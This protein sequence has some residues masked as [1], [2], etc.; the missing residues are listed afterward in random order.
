MKNLKK[1]NRN[2]LRTIS[3]NGLL[4]NVTGAVGGLGAAIGGAVGGAGN[5]V[6]GVVGGT[7]GVVGGAIGATGNLAANTL[8][9]V[10]CVVNGIV[11]IKLLACGSTC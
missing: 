7:V 9:E 2:E 5:I 6:G 1:L 10:Q 3:G 11:T 8:C 4:D